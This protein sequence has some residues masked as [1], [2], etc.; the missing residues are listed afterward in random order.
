MRRSA[1][2]YVGRSGPKATLAGYLTAGVL[3]PGTAADF[4]AASLP[5]KTASEGFGGGAKYT[6][7]V[8][9]QLLGGD[10]L[11]INGTQALSSQERARPLG[12]P[13]YALHF[14]SVI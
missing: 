5:A 6:A 2:A 1:K 3:A 4:A 14:C 9:V 12:K 8:M 13:H 11:E 7:C 10:V